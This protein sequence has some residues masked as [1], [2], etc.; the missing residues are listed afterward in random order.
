MGGEG[1]RFGSGDVQVCVDVLYACTCRL[2]VS[3]KF[4]MERTADVVDAGLKLV[5]R[6]LA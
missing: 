4:P 1:C 2:S 3:T 6:C 5:T